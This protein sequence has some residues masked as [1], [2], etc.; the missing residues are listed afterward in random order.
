M[1]TSIQQKILAQLWIST[2]HSNLTN[3]RVHCGSLVLQLTIIKR[4]YGTSSR[5]REQSR[6]PSWR[7][8]LAAK[9]TRFN[10]AARN[11][12]GLPFAT[13]V[14]SKY[15]V[16]DTRPWPYVLCVCS[17]CRVYLYSCVQVFSHCLCNLCMTGVLENKN[18]DCGYT[19]V[20]NQK[21]L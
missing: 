14:A 1:A 13:A 5:C 11:Q 18:K 6:T 16:Y 9:S 15:C 20:I 21:R 17:L 12:T 19:L 8:Q 2:T 4:S 3:A 7:T 10:G